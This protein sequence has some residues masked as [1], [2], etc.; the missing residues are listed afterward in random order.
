MTALHLLRKS[1]QAK[2]WANSEG[3]RGR[4]RPMRSRRTSY[5]PH[6]AFA[7][8]HPAHLLLP[9]PRREYSPSRPLSVLR[10]FRRR[11]HRCCSSQQKICREERSAGIRREDETERCGSWL[12]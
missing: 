10:C 2:S 1:Q 6:P 7:V 9:L 5:L 4:W 11:L 12:V 8:F 3:A